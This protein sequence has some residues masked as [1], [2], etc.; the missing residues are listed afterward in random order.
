MKKLFKII[1]SKTPKVGKKIAKIGASLIG[2]SLAPEVMPVSA[3]PEI[4]ESWLQLAQ[5]ILAIIGIFFTGAGV[6]STVSNPDELVKE[7]QG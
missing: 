2:V 7:Y 4:P 3:L 6:A 5:V 1:K